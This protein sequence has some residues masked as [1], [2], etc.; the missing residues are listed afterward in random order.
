MGTDTPGGMYLD[1]ELD[2]PRKD[3]SLQET[4]KPSSI[5]DTTSINRFNITTTPKKTTTA[6]IAT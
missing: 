1:L 6:T 3:E 2:P 5:I 4:E